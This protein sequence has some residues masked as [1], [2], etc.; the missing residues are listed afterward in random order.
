MPRSALLVNDGRSLERA[1]PRS[2]AAAAATVATA[3]TRTVKHV[4]A[5][6]P[7]VR[8]APWPSFDGQPPFAVTRLCRT[9][10]DTEVEAAVGPLYLPAWLHAQL[11]SAFYW[12]PSPTTGRG[13]RETDRRRPGCQAGPCISRAARVGRTDRLGLDSLK[14]LGSE[15]VANGSENMGECGRVWENVGERLGFV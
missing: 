5:S 8:L 1:T 6:D 12:M 3:S 4:R 13:T 14:P 11:R 9:K 7:A 10:A 2:T 15:Q